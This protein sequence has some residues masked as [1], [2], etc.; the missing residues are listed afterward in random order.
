M[1]SQ[2]FYRVLWFACILLLLF[3]LYIPSSKEEGKATA[4]PAVAFQGQIF[5]G[6]RWKRKGGYESTARKYSFS[7]LKERTG[8]IK[9]EETGDIEG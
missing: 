8:E 7:A 6:D 5:T 2:G 1:V 3:K 4:N 9:L